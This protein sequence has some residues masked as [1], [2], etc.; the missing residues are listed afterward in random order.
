[1]TK[2]FLH[3]L[4]YLIVAISGFRIINLTLYQG[5]LLSDFMSGLILIGGGISLFIT[6]ILEIYYESKR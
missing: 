5:R 6:G 2:S 1:M 3:F 4:F